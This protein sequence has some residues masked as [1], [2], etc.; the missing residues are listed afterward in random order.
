ML[1]KDIIAVYSQNHPERLNTK[2]NVKDVC[3]HI[4]TTTIFQ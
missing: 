2:Y 3:G 1:I 4:I